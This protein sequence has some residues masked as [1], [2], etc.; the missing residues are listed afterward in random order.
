MIFSYIPHRHPFSHNVAL[1]RE[2]WMCNWLNRC[3][4]HTVSQH[5]LP[6]L[7]DLLICSG[8]LHRLPESWPFVLHTTKWHGWSGTSH[9][10][11]VSEKKTATTVLTRHVVFGDT[12]I[13]GWLPAFEGVALVNATLAGVPTTRSKTTIMVLLSGEWIGFV[14]ANSVLISGT[15]LNRARFR[16]EWCRTR[17]SQPTLCSKRAFRSKRAFPSKQVILGA[18]GCVCHYFDIIFHYHTRTY[19][20]DTLSTIESTLSTSR[21]YWPCRWHRNQQI[22]RRLRNHLVSVSLTCWLKTDRHPKSKI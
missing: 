6:K 7:N 9:N 17:Q 14:R 10:V 19:N 18:R 4:V 22:I 20:R 3:L 11:V 5:V 2:K 1:T 16:V 21:Q 13:A 8:D 15:D 12:S